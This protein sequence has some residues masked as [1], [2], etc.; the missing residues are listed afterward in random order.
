MSLKKVITVYNEQT[1]RSRTVAILECDHCGSSKETIYNKTHHSCEKLS[2]CNR[3]CRNVS[4]KKGGKAAQKFAVTNIKRYGVACAL[5][6]QGVQEKVKK[7]NIERYGCERPFQSKEIQKKID[8]NVEKKYGVSNISK[9]QSVK[10]R[11]K[12]TCQEKYSVDSI[13]QSDEFKQKSLVTHLEKYGVKNISHSLE[14]LEKKRQTY[15][16]NWG[17]DHPTKSQDYLAR[18][19]FI[20]WRKKIHQT[21]KQNGSYARSKSE[22]ECFKML[23]E[24]FRIENVQ[25]QEIVN[26]WSIDF[27]I[28]PIKTYIQFDGIYWHGLNKPIEEI[29]V[30]QRPRDKNIAVVYDRDREQERWFK[31]NGLKLVRVT[32]RAFKKDPSVFI[33]GLIDGNPIHG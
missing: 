28:K 18:F 15:L 14:H 3:E 11:V 2:F 7:T 8:E 4:L 29:R 30:S 9:L 25:R 33:N 23:C 17:V 24:K 26:G 12:Q 13:T 32:D 19:D 1:K 27:F 5:A 31:E 21:M 10:D 6:S 20:A 16:K 22:D